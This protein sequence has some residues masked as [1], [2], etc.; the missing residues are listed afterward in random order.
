MSQYPYGPNGFYQHGETQYSPIDRPKYGH[1]GKKITFDELP[2]DCKKAVL[3][4]YKEI[5]GLD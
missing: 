1:L 5:W 3:D 2:E 4:D